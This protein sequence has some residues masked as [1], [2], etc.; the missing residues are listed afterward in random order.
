[1]ENKAVSNTGPILHLTELNSIQILKMFSDV[2][3]PAEVFKELSKFSIPVPNFITIKKLNK[4]SK[5]MVKILTNKFNLDFG[6]AHAISLMLQEKTD[7]FLTDDLDARMAAN[8]LNLEVHGTVGVI[9]RAFKNKMLSKQEAIEIVNR[10][11]Q[12][13]SLFITQDLINDIIKSINSYK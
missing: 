5:D 13:S 12:S 11:Q 4:S 1:M 3:I 10:L 8:S 6:E 7:Y 9:L 2:F